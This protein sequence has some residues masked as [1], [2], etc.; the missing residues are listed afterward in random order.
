MN[1]DTTSLPVAV[2]LSERTLSR[3]FKTKINQHESLDATV[4]RLLSAAAQRK[5][6]PSRLPEPQFVMQK[7]STQI[8]SPQCSDQKYQGILLGEPFGA[9][10]LYGL[11]GAFVDLID[12][13]DPQAVERLS[14]LT[15]RRRRY[16]A[17]SPGA[18]HP[19]RKNL[20]TSRTRTGWWIS[21]N[22]GRA[23]IVR[24]LKAASTALGLRYG[25]DVRLL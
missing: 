7:H 24:A 23:D 19:G 4:E 15:S 2:F 5:G 13:L 16:V 8:S 6:A 11:F 20:P 10:T 17:R 3:L 22:V 25:T 21:A 9:T 14:E 1:P 18:I 12:D